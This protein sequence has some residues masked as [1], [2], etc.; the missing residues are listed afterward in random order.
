MLREERKLTASGEPLI[1]A[2]RGYSA[3]YPENTG[4]SFDRAIDCGADGIECDVQK[5]ADDE[6]VILHDETVDRTSNGS[7]RV[8]QLAL[9]QLKQLD[10]GRGER[11]LTI[12][13]LVARIPEGKWINFEIKQGTLSSG[14]MPDLA[15][16]IYFLRGT[17]NVMI[18]SFDHDLL[19]PFRSA[20]FATAML[21]GEEHQSLGVKALLKRVLRIQPK[22]LNL[23]IQAFERVGPGVVKAL[24]LGARLL[25]VKI[26]FWTVNTE[27]EFRRVAGVSAF[28]ITDQPELA[29]TVWLSAL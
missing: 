19:P 28:V 20:G 3:Q 29:R 16:Q 12:A 21:L 2:H 27:A 10:F 26:C 25:R 24:L 17:R 4:L 6:F 9:A 5:T 11:I 23:P 18:S 7:G 15:R 14:D 1:L 22:F 13:E 8:D